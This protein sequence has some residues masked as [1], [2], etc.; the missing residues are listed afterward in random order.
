MTRLTNFNVAITVVSLFVM[1]AKMIGLIMKVYKPLAGAF[2]AFAMM[3]LYATSIYGQVGPD[4][5]DPRYPSPVAWYI[6]KDCSYAKPKGYYSLCMIAK[7]SLAVT[8]Y[9]LYVALSLY[10]SVVAHVRKQN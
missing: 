4:Y 5:S 2:F 9:M 3:A 10:L 1:L 6:A 7:G 8:V